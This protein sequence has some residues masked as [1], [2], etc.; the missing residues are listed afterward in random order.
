MKKFAKIAFVAI[1][2]AIAGYG[3]YINHKNDSISDLALANIEALARYELP[4]VEIVCNGGDHGVCLYCHRY[5][6]YD[7][8]YGYGWAY[9]CLTSG[10]PEDW[11]P[12]SC[13]S[14]GGGSFHA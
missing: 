1:F 6:V 4:E 7:P 3:V 8:Y 5:E 9:E 10:D 2:T 12:S 13:N 14:Y 11:C